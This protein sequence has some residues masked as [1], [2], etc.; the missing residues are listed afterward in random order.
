LSL[1][2]LRPDLQKS[3]GKGK[4]KAKVD[5]NVLDDGYFGKGIYFSFY[6]DYAMWYSGAYSSI[7]R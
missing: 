3:K 7:A 2:R 6:S 5:I 1:S 4:G